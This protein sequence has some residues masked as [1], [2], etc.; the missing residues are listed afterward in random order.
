MIGEALTA[1]P[2]QDLT[3]EASS[4]LTLCHLIQQLTHFWKIW[5]H[6]YLMQFQPQNN[7]KSAQ[8]NIKI[9]DLV[10][11]KEDYMLP[12]EWLLGHIVVTHPRKDNHTHFVTKLELVVL[13]VQW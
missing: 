10:I 2:K 8:V 6:E 3:N 9:A 13:N 11:L 5:Y 1:I 4:V 12:S 7:W